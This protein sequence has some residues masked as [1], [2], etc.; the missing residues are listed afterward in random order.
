MNA[1]LAYA[2]LISPK[3]RIQ[4]AVPIPDGQRLTSI[5]A[6]LSKHTHKPVSEFRA[7][8]KSKALGLPSY[9]NGNAEGY[10]Y[11]ATYDIPPGTSALGILQTIVAQFNAQAQTLG[12]AQAATPTH[13]TAGQ[14]ITAAS[15]LEVEGTPKDY[16]KVARVIDNRLAAGMR[17]QFDST[18]LYA[19]HKTGFFLSNAQLQTTPSPYNTFLHT[20]LPPGP[21]DNPT[22]AAIEA[23][24]H[25]APGNWVYF[26]TV[27]PK[28]GITKFTDSKAQFDQFV[29]ECQ[30]N[31][32]C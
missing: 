7:A 5:L 2:M 11:P 14:I 10:L 17:L 25:P 3:S 22:A 9:A 19:L 30:A 1:A 23:V 21:I 13:L 4:T 24:L 26:V 28:N 32:A 6:E 16:A 18:V 15:L 27:D 20:G 8:L 29:L 12:L 31:K